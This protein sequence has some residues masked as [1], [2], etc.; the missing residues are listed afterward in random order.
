MAVIVKRYTVGNSRPLQLFAELKWKEDLCPSIPSPKPFNFYQAFFDS[1][2]CN[3]G[4]KLISSP[5]YQPELQQVF[6]EYKLPFVQSCL[7]QSIQFNDYPAASTV[8]YIFPVHRSIHLYKC[9]KNIATQIAAQFS[10][11]MRL[12]YYLR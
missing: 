4:I 3:A 9:N 11:H 2:V 1:I 10:Q 12:S 6:D 7:L 5:E 8:G